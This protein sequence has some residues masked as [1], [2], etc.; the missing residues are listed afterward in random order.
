MHIINC[1]RTDRVLLIIPTCSMIVV[2]NRC[3]ALETT[4][5][6]T[7][8]IERDR[9]IIQTSNDSVFDKIPS[10]KV[11]ATRLLVENNLNPVFLTLV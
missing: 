7:A 5:Y 3:F 9:T 2:Q 4:L 11:S 6:P 10:R 8:Y 1:I